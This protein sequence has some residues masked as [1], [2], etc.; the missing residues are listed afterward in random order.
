MKPESSQQT[1]PDHEPLKRRGS[2][3]AAP[4]IRRQQILNAA[5][6]CISQHGFHGTTTDMIATDSGL[7]KG[8]VYRFFKSK[9]ELFIAII[10]FMSHE[11]ETRFSEAAPFASCRE[12]LLVRCNNQYDILNEYPDLLPVFG[13]FYSHAATRTKLEEIY[14]EDI[15]ILSDILE[16][17]IQSNEFN[18]VDIQSFAKMIIW[19]VDEITQ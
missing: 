14:R 17:G 15:K 3:H 12:E 9:D 5:I 4:E 11:Q 6:R 13:D 7:S 1:T 10:D 8:S 18:P 2:S 16:R 19:T